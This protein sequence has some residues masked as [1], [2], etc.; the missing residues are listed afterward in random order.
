MIA[1]G[2]L[3][4]LAA[5]AALGSV[6]FDVDLHEARPF[7]GGRATSFPVSPSGAPSGPDSERIDNCQ[8]VLLRCCVNLLDF[9]R[10]CGVLDKIHFYEE[11]H[12]V[13]PG[14][15]V[16]RLKA[17]LLPAPLHFVGSFLRF[18]ALGWR[19]KMAVAGGLRA[20][21]RECGR[22]DLDSMTFA[23]WLAGRWQTD[24]AM[25]RFWRPVVV[26]ALNE[27]PE[28]VSAQPAFQV[29]QQGFLESADGYHMGVPAVPLAE[30]YSAA[31]EKR[32]GERVRVHL[33]SP[34]ARLDPADGSADF[35][36]S[37]VPF[38]RV[39]ELVSGLNLELAKFEHS[40]ITGIHLWLDREI[41][42]LPQAALLDRTIQWIFRKSSRYY[43]LV[44]SASRRLIPMGRQEVIDLA[45]AE[46]QEFFPA[47]R[48]ARVERAHV[49]K[50][51]RATY[52]AAPGVEAVRPGPETNFSNVFLAGDWTQS[53]WPATMEGAVRSGYRAAEAICRAGGKGARFV[54]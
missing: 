7:L 32:L 24:K 22:T 33:R 31:L 43:Q 2:G 46:L 15:R 30:L 28:R 21:R 6:G 38:E 53:G 5:A 27:E 18:G 51:A 9:Y 54:V 25:A 12:F 26:S 1:G 36:L 29:F 42:E 44:V 52:S 49:I 23:S 16:S 8:H 13:E 17:G 19:D 4:G 50:E 10:R 39:N 45:W 11:Y 40:P 3:A 14:G 48:G 41:T 35:Y 37:A 47:A 34:V 20:M